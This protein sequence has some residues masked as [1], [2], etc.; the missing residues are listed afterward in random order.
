MENGTQMTFEGFTE[1]EAKA[2]VAE[3]QPKQTLLF[4]GVE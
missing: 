1:E 2:M 3:A 4:G